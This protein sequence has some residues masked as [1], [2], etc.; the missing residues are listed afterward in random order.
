MKTDKYLIDQIKPQESSRVFRVMAE[1]VDGFDMLRSVPPA[2]TVFGS[3]RTPVDHP[4][5]EAARAAAR[6]RL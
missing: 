1:F 5:Y 6:K 3:A 4:D 2:V